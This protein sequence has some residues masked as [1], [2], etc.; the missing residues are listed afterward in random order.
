MVLHSV[1][2]V[3]RSTTFPWLAAM[4]VFCFTPALILGFDGWILRKLFE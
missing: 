3:T 4:S 2:I 1:Y